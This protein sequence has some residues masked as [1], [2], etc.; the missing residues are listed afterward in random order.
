MANTNYLYYSPRPIAL[1]AAA[2]DTAKSFDVNMEGFDT[3]VLQINYTRSSATAL[4]FTF[5]APGVN[6]TGNQYFKKKV[7]YGANT[8][9]PAGGSGAVPF[10]LS[11]TATERFEVPFSLTGLGLYGAGQVRVTITATGGAAG[12]TVTVT[13]IALRTA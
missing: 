1:T 4:V 2:L 6:D 13:P 8:V 9:T 7:D 10:S 5:S 3:L 11:V 12:D